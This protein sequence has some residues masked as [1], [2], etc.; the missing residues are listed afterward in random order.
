MK[1]PHAYLPQTRTRAALLGAEIARARL[2]RRWSQ[3][4]LAERAGISVRTLRKVESG[5]LTTALGTVL[6]LSALVGLDLIGTADDMRALDQRAQERL[7]LLPSRVRI[8]ST[9]S[10]DNDF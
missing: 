3:E 2:D 4:D 5:A 6:E 8:R 9:D 7:R 1:N 10:V